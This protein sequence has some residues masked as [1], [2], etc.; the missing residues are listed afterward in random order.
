MIRTLAF[1]RDFR[2]YSGGHGKLWDYFN[3][4]NAHPAWRASV[5]LTPGS[6]SAENPWLAD[7]ATID[8]DW[9]PARADALLL[10]GMDWQAYP[11]DAPARPVINLVQGVRHADPQHRLYH[12]LS[13]RA[14]RI[15][16][17]APVA[18]AIQATGQVNGPV[19]VIQA[20]LRLPGLD[21]TSSMR[22]GIF[23]GALKQPE[24]GRAL[25]A[26][27]QR[28]GRTVILADHWMPRLDYLAQLATA[29]VAVLLPL[30]CEGFFLPALEAMALG[31]ATVVPDCIGN[32]AYLAPGDNA[33]VPPM[34]LEALLQA[35]KQLDDAALRMRLSQAGVQTAA[36]FDL[37]RERAAFHA[38]LDDLDTLWRQ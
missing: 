2:R 24:L 34:Q 1:H 11:H 8:R 22:T 3:H 5:Y 6:A 21:A 32:R 20:A 19:R 37:E 12:F 38:L 10:G 14:I 4:A 31:C 33:L 18:E 16:V 29:E 15:C 28:E 35:V 7:P 13:R 26:D 36:R 25:A 17:G 9:A 27:L 30:E 23:I